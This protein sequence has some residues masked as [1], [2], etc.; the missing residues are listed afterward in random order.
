MHLPSRESGCMPAAFQRG[1]CVCVC[2]HG[3]AQ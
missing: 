1:V 3:A 2:M